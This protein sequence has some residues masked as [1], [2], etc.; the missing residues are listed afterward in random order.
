MTRRDFVVSKAARELD[1]NRRRDASSS[2]VGVGSVAT[3]VGL[4]GGGIPGAKVDASRLGQMRFS[5]PGKRARDL[6]GA[7]RGGVFGYRQSAH[8]Q[9]M[10]RQMA[11]D[12]HYGNAQTTRVN[13]FLRGQGRGKVAPEKKIIGHMR[14]GRIASNALLAGGAGL[15]AAGVYGRKKDK[16]A[17]RDTRDV[18]TALM[19]GGGTVATA[20]GLGSLALDRQGRKWAKRSE[21]DLKAASKIVPNM[22]GYTVRQGRGRVPDVAP[23]KRTSDILGDKRILA[24]KSRAQA[25]AAGKLRGSAAQGR[26]F[27][28]VYGSSG[29][30]ARRVGIPAGLN[31][32]AVGAY[33]RFKD[34]K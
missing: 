8:Q 26:Y 9:F 29:S 7:T 20:S 22:G 32:A 28:R 18:D 12:R 19:A 33:G 17:K 25:Q 31:A 21:S 14:R 6:A 16:V 11:D 15:T 34:Q 4:V 30:V 3:G 27:A 13:H 10:D 5:S 24:G 1:P 23:D 2:A